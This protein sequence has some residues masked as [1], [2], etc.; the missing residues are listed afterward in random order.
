MRLRLLVG[1]GLFVTVVL[2]ISQVVIYQSI[3]RMLRK[4]IRM[5]LL[6][7]ASILAK[8]AELEIDKVVYEWQ[9][10]LE[11]NADTSIAGL[12]QFWD[13][14]TGNAVGSPAL[15][16][17]SLEMF[18]GELNQSIIREVVLPD[19]RPALAVGLMHLPFL[20]AGTFEE[21]KALG[22]FLRPEDFPQVL[23]CARETATLDGKLTRMK[24]HLVRAGSATLLTIWLSILT[25]TIWTM[26]PIRELERRLEESSKKDSG[27]IPEIPDNL[28]VELRGLAEAFNRTLER[29]EAARD[30]ERDF[31]LHAAH[32][33]R[34]PIAG[35]QATLEQALHRER[36]QDDL[37]ERIGNALVLTEDMRGTIQSL[38]KLARVRGRIEKVES[39]EF[40]PWEL[41]DEILA[42]EGR[43]IAER[44]LSVARDFQG[45]FR[46]CQSDRSL[47]KI[48]IMTLV[49]NAVRYAPAGSRIELRA[50]EKDGRFLLRIENE[51]FDL[52]QEDL[53]R[54][55]EPFQRGGSTAGEGAGLGLSLAREIAELLG[56]SVKMELSEEKDRVLVEL[57]LPEKVVIS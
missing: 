2:L 46:A 22:R 52:G 3:A 32:E 42:S 25:I 51:C 11:S 19:G 1:T 53:A 40:D 36:S 45:P 9:E 49:D 28:P 50:A 41:V 23:V 8:S 48:V 26:R 57:T 20:D 33:L 29:V 6:E 31:A 43:R 7:S 30:R 18:H 47:V 38:M 13:L 35:I 55:F 4:E 24:W 17:G 5:Q 34:T 12:F 14:N 56:G 44:K 15:K 27:A 21:M 16:G 54:V 10:A 39:D 37:R